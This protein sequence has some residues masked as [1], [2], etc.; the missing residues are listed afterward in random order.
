MDNTSIDIPITEDIPVTEDEILQ[1]FG[2]RG[3]HW[4]VRKSR[5]N[6][7]ERKSADA[8][9]HASLKRKSVNQL[10]DAELKAVVNR[11]NM[12]QQFT[13]LNP[14]KIKKGHNFVRGLLAVSVTVNTAVK[15]AKSP[16]G[17][18]LKRT[19]K[20]AAKIPVNSIGRTV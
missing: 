19:L 10:S 14:T 12:E 16:T 18:A 20:N 1:H 11:L 15:F 6:Q 3:M 8:K 17:Q 9:A 2:V 5:A 13:K 7:V 4:G